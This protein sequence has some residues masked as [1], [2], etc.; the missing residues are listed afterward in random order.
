MKYI[1]KSYQIKIAFASQN[2]KFLWAVIEE[3]I[4]GEQQ[5]LSPRGLQICINLHRFLLHMCMNHHTNLN[6]EILHAKFRNSYTEFSLS[7][8]TLSIPLCKAYIRRWIVFSFLHEIW[9]SKN[10][11]RKIF[12]KLL[13]SLNSFQGTAT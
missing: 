2:E 12:N 8:F 9:R 5:K 4:E 13:Y 3:L 6:I 11:R 10:S 7:F 1:L